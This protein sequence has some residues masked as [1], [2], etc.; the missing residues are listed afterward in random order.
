MRISKKAEYALRAALI[1]AAA[2]PGRTLQIQELAESGTIPVKFL[3]QILLALKNGGL[4]RSKRGVG[5]GYQLDRPPRSISVGEI[6]T[7]IDGSLSGLA[8]G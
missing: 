7:I 6:I 3:E 5:G 8:Q 1:L 4:L 2:A